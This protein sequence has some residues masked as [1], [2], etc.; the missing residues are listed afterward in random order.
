MWE[1]PQIICTDVPGTIWEWKRCPSALN[2]LYTNL[3]FSRMSES[4]V[5]ISN[6]CAPF[7]KE[8]LKCSREGEKMKD[9]VKLFAKDVVC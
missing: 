7:P 8:P 2:N 4:C 6:A 3:P 1:V 9:M 5:F